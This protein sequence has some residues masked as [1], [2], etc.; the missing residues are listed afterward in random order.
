MLLQL[1]FMPLVFRWCPWVAPFA[2]R[3]KYNCC[4]PCWKVSIFWLDLVQQFSCLLYKIRL[5]VDRTQ[6]S[7]WQAEAGDIGK[8]LKELRCRRRRL[9]EM[10]Q[11]AAKGA[12][13]ICPRK[14]SAWRKCTQQLSLT[15]SLWQ[16]R[17]T[18][19]ICSAILPVGYAGRMS[20]CSHMGVMKCCGIS[21]AVVILPV[22]SGC[23]WGH[24]GGAC[25]NFMGIHWARTSWSGRGG[26]SR[27]V[28][29]WCVT[30]SICLWRI[31]SPMKLELL[32]SVASSDK[33]V[34]LGGYAED[35]RQLWTQ[36]LAK[37]LWAQFMIIAGPLST[38][39]AW[40]R[41]EVLVSSVNFRNHFVSFPIYLVVL[42]LIN[43]YNWNAT[44]KSVVRRW[45]G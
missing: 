6:W 20:P 24:L 4:L 36:E 7:A 35:G 30:V 10:R 13:K 18:L 40:K 31:W 37:K 41:D 11:T 8:I 32:P 25:W 27:R 12:Q 1:G 17:Q 26:R 39:V 45:L 43:H 44:R 16:D 2:R 28:P 19:P 3:R 14:L 29:L 42:L 15:G 34:L 5:Y 33:G 38:E 9:A 22:I 21:K 23:V